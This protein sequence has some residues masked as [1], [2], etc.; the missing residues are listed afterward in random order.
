[1]KFQKKFNCER[2]EPREGNFPF[3]C[4]VSLVVLL[5]AAAGLAQQL[6]VGHATDFTSHTY[7][8]PPNEQTVKMKLSGAEASPLPGGL[9]DVKRLQ[10]ETFT[11]A[12]KPEA[13][14]HAPQC[15]YAPMDGVASSAGRLEMQT[16][17]GKLHVEGEG[18]LWR[19]AD[20][21][22]IISN[23]VHTVIDLPAQQPSA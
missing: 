20:S 2:R 11:V 14:I 13:I 6:P 16:A 12:G 17:D 10:I 4:L 22:L 18:F 23:R 3:V 7:F 19:Q 8:E 5:T 9:L 21:V 15:T 1:M